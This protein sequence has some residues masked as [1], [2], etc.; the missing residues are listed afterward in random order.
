MNRALKKDVTS[1]LQL[2]G[3]LLGVSVIAKMLRYVGNVIVARYTTVEDF[4]AYNLFFQL[5]GYIST[6]AEFGI[7]SAII[8]CHLRL[9]MSVNRINSIISVYLVCIAIIYIIFFALLLAFINGIAEW[10]PGET[11]VSF[12]LPYSLFLILQNSQVAMLRAKKWDTKFNV[13]IA[14]SGLAFLMTIIA[15]VSVESVT[16]DTAL[17]AAAIALMT[18]IAANYY[19]IGIKEI[20]PFKLSKV[21]V[22][23]LFSLG[24]KNY[25][26]RLLSTG[27]QFLPMGL[28]FTLGNLEAMGFFAVAVFFMSF[29]RMANQS[30]SLLLTAKLSEISDQQSLQFTLI[31]LTI[32]GSLF[33]VIGIPLMFAMEE[34]I[35]AIY[36]IRYLDAVEISRFAIVSVIFECLTITALRPFVTSESHHFAILYYVYTTVIVMMLAM[37][38]LSF[39]L[40]VGILH[41]IGVAMVFCNV[42]G[43]AF[44]ITSFALR[45]NRVVK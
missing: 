40:G 23:S 44:A 7:P 36:G 39:L 37:F 41:S 30:V 27:A 25:A 8:Y 16:L 15:L 28:L 9:G 34:L 43:F 21:D 33:F 18:S 6:I 12:L 4:G 20:I 5:S 17:G 13:S 19:L 35:T 10:S 42:C 11:F 3:I 31:L 45:Y 29:V 1:F 14:V 26:S 22:V 24:S 32:M 38:S 2:S